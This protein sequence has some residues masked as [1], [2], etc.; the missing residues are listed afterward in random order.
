MDWDILFVGDHDCFDLPDLTP[1]PSERETASMVKL[2]GFEPG[3]NILDAPCGRGWHVN[4]LAAQGYSV[5]GIDRDERFL[6][7]AADEAKTMGVDIDCRRGIC[8]RCPSTPNSTPPSPG[9]SHS[10]TST[11]KPTGT[12]FTGTDVHCAPAAVSCW[13]AL[14][15]PT[16]TECPR[17]P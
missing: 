7:T 5:V 4:V 10:D 13:T 17:Q 14:P 3:V 15:V 16:H 9:A 12:S 2:G 8:E 11:T 6:A 1:E